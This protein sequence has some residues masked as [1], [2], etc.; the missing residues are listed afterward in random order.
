MDA[1]DAVQPVSQVCVA[2]RQLS[3]NQV[4]DCFVCLAQVGTYVTTRSEV[5]KVLLSSMNPKNLDCH[6]IDC[7][8]MI[9]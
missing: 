2:I 8:H 7:H 6:S 4:I 1:N 3:N 5:L 9:N